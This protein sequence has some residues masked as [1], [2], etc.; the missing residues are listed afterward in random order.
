MQLNHDSAFAK[1]YSEGVSKKQYWEPTFEDSMSLIAK[2]P[3]I[4]GRIYRNVYGHGKLPA[5]NPDKD[6]G[7]NLAN[8][9]G[10]GENDT[11][12]E[13]MRLYLTL[14]RSEYL[15]VVCRMR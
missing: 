4:A 15:H 3:T 10:F 5:I 1:A 2:L 13:L 12:V 6:Y 14:H 9:L 7:Y 11:F 8:F